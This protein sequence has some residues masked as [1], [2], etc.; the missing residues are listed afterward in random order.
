M[1]MF[2]LGIAFCIYS[3]VLLMIGANIGLEL[4]VDRTKRIGYFYAYDK[5]YEAVESE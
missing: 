2:L 1:N 3:F 5:K 4:A